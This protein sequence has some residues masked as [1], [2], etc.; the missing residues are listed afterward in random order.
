MILFKSHL[1]PLIVSGRKTTTRRS[2]KKRWRE[3]AVHECR[4]NYFSKPFALVRI[5]RVYQ[6]PLGAMTDADARREGLASLESFK[7]EWVKIYGKWTPRTIVWVVDFSLTASK[8]PSPSLP[9]PEE[10]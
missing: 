2:G 4:T 6:Q 9:F 3:G 8:N 10:S 5:D 1:A 7:G